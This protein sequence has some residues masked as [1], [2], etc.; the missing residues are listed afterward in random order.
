MEDPISFNMRTVYYIMMGLY[1]KNADLS[2]F[3]KNTT[4]SALQ[5]LTRKLQ[6]E[7]PAAGDKGVRIE[8]SDNVDKTKTKIIFPQSKM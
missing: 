8:K 4:T 7:E 2:K 6:G 3:V 5:R 1:D